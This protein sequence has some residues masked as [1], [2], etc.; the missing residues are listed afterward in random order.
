MEETR[1]K[2]V[3]SFYEEYMEDDGNTNLPV[4]KI[5]CFEGKPT[6]IQVIQNDKTKEESI[7]YFNTNWELL[8][9]RQN[10]PNSI[11]HLSRPSKLDEMIAIAEKLSKGHHFLRIDLYEINGSV[12]FSEYTFFTDA[13][14]E[15]YHPDHWDKDFGQMI[16][17]P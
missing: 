2:I 7:D 6:V 9:L 17:V 8:D 16:N 4:Y 13:G 11:N 1:E 3:S 10:F 14:F 5:F 15:P 12:F